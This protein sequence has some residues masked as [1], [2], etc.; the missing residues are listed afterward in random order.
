MFFE[1][2]SL[3]YHSPITID[4][5][6]YGVYIGIAQRAHVYVAASPW[7]I[8]LASVLL[9][10][11]ISFPLA[12]LF[13]PGGGTIWAPAIL[14]FVIQA[15]VKVIVLPH[16]AESFAL[17]W[18]AASA[19]VSLLV[20]TVRAKPVADRLHCASKTERGRGA[21]LR[22]PSPQVVQSVTGRRMNVT[23]TFTPPVWLNPRNVCRCSPTKPV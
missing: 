10:V 8:A 11:V 16:G 4:S 7:P 13:E 21:T 1:V 18:M 9:A 2:S 6:T 12:Y 3:T 14:H 15:T 19:T 17:A 5:C 22:S 20:F 23:R